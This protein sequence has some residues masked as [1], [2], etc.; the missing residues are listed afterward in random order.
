MTSD[1]V[2]IDAHDTNSEVD[3]RIARLNRLL[4]AFAARVGCADAEVV[5]FTGLHQLHDH[6]GNLSSVWKTN[7]DMEVWSST[8]ADLWEK[9]FY[10]RT[11]GASAIEKTTDKRAMHYI[12]Y[13]QEA[14][15]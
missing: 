1:N 14:L 4:G 6:K 9:Q 15:K 8:L 3:W 5:E 11:E 13:F 2:I 12:K 7:M 10:E